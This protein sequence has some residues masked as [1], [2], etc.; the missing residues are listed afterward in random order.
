MAAQPTQKAN[1]PQAN[2]PQT[3]L[4]DAERLGLYAAIVTA[5][6]V[7]LLCWGGVV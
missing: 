1:S 2:E 4:D 5:M 6:I 3:S 7:A